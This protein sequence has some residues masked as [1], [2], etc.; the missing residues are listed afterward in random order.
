MLGHLLREHAGDC[1]THNIATCA[2]TLDAWSITL[3][4]AAPQLVESPAGF[5]SPSK[6]TEANDTAVNSAM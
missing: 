1:I 6:M 2:F 3:N 5:L 4:V